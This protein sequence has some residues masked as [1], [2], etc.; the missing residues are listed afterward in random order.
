[1]E[2]KENKQVTQPAPETPPQTEAKVNTEAPSEDKT[3]EGIFISQKCECDSTI[4]NND[5]HDLTK[6]TREGVQHSEPRRVASGETPVR[7]PSER[8]ETA[9]TGL[10]RQRFALPS[11]RG[12][13]W[14][15]KG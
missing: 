6:T 11:G 13:V 5:S 8:G 7:D 4:D 3:P 10:S 15:T 9:T 14:T 1:M 12:A 2:E